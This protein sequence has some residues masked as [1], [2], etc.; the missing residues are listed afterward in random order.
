MNGKV[1]FAITLVVLIV[2]GG[3]FFADWN[4][5]VPDKVE[6]TYLGRDSCVQC[7]QAEAAL[8]HGS[9]HDLAMDLA[10]EE[11]VLG[12]FSEQKLEHH[13]ITSKMFRSGDRFMINT[14]GPDGQMQDFEVKYVFGVEPL[15][16]YM[17]ELERPADAEADEI[18]RVQVLR[19]SWD[20]EKRSGFI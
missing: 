4:R 17:V 15:Q 7:H 19:V 6:A 8:F 5:S 16:Q 11:F 1:G 3:Y 9:H 10:T 20:S 18:G 13:G 12:N 14:E 2:S